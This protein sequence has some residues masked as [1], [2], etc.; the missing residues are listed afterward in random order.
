M[1]LKKAVREYNRKRSNRSARVRLEEYS[2]G[3]YGPPEGDRCP[4]CENARWVVSTGAH[5][6]SARHIAMKYG[7]SEY[8]L[9]KAAEAYVEEHGEVDTQFAWKNVTFIGG[10]L[11]SQRGC[12]WTYDE[13]VEAECDCN[14]HTGDEIPG[15]ACG[16]GLYCLWNPYDAENYDT[17]DYQIVVKLELGGNVIECEQGARAQYAVVLGISK[18]YNVAMA[19][20]ASEATGI[21]LIDYDEEDD[22]E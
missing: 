16:C 14:E 9:I 2:D 4:L 17:S 3:T 15:E 7:V 10:K 1:S 21:P 13:V 18:T 20:A 6:K 11:R 22:D 12:E 19:K 5:L 8:A